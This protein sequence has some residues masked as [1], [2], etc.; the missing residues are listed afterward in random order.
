MYSDPT[1]WIKR[2]IPKTQETQI[3][4]LS[5]PT[6]FISL[7]T[8]LPEETDKKYVTFSRIPT[9]SFLT[10]K[11]HGI[12]MKSEYYKNLLQVTMRNETFIYDLEDEP[13]ELSPREI[14]FVHGID[15]LVD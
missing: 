14:G 12:G 5:E 11:A 7:D 3:E 13:E 1:I 8:I 4:D 9:S 15:Q 2:V 6:R 10:V